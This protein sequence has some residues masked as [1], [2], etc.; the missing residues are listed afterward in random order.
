[1][2]L[3]PSNVV[4]ARD[5]ARCCWVC[6]TTDE[7]DKGRQWARPCR[8]TGATQ[9]V[10]QSC[11]ISWVDE[12]QQGDPTAT[13]NCPQCLAPYTIFLPDLPRHWAFYEAA[14]HLVTE[15]SPAASFSI[16]FGCVYTSAF[17]FGSVA[18]CQF[19]GVEEGIDFLCSCNRA[20]LSLGLPLIP[21]ALILPRFV[22]MRLSFVSRAAQP[23]NSLPLDDQE[24]DGNEQAGPEP[25]TSMEVFLETQSKKT[26]VSRAVL[27]GLM[28]PSVASALGKFLYGRMCSNVYK[29]AMLGSLTYLIGK[30]LIHQSYERC[31]RERLQWRQVLDYKWE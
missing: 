14:D 25:T 28:F 26:T 13:V 27:G 16:A 30:R 3:V 21:I 29:R 18:V 17:F 15:L 4:P 5:V 23:T 9:W 7:E 6:L 12:K 31:C 20:T 22:H 1:M 2:A 8:C 10:H 24:R 19:V 11:I